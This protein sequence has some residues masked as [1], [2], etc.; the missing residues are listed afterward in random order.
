MVFFEHLMTAL[1]YILGRSYCI[2]FI[3]VPLAM[4]LVYLAL[5]VLKGE[6]TS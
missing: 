3:T 5:Y 6:R 2:W 4:A 1:M